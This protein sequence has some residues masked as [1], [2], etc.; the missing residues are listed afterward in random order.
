MLFY[1]DPYAGRRRLKRRYRF[2]LW[3]FGLGLLFGAGLAQLL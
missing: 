1:T 2:A 3:G